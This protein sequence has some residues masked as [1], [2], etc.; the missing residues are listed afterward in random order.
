MTWIKL[1]R[2]SEEFAKAAHR[3]LGQQHWS[4]AQQL[5]ALAASYERRALE[6]VDSSK[7]RTFGV[8]AVSATALNFKAS[9]LDQAEAVVQRSLEDP[10]LPSF[11]HDQLK[12]LLSSIQASREKRNAEGDE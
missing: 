4:R 1:H 2:S 3:A 6:S 10:R 9:L 5:F 8:T 12:E 11:A 7:A